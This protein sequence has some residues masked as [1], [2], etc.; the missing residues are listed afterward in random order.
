MSLPKFCLFIES[1]NIPTHNNIRKISLI[2]HTFKQFVLNLPDR[3]KFQ[4]IIIVFLKRS[5]KSEYLQIVIW[6]CSPLF[7]IRYFL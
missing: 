6:G 7:L 5:L 1:L 4:G 2:I 3:K